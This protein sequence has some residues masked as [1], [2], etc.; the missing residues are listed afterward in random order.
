[1][2][3]GPIRTRAGDPRP[4]AVGFRASLNTYVRFA[5]TGAFAA[6]L[7]AC[8]SVPT[9]PHQTAAIDPKNGDGLGGTGIQQMAQVQPGD[10]LGGTGIIGT[11]SGFGSIIVNGLELEFDHSTAV[12]ND[13]RPTSLD[14]LRVGQVIQGVARQ[15]DGRMHLE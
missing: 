7:A 15:K 14:E 12:G 1:M 8:A 11:I 5:L 10:G 2:T 4:S 9:V 6:L 13:G 3:Q